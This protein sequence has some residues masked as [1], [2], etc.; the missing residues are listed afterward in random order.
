MQGVPAP[1]VARYFSDDLLELGIFRLALEDRKRAGERK[2]S[3][4][5]GGEVAREKYLVVL[6]DAREHRVYPVDAGEAV[7]TVLRDRDDLPALAPHDRI[8]LK[9][10]ARFR[11][12]GIN[13]SVA[14]F[15]RVAELR[16]PIK[17]TP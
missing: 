12:A 1:H 7:R 17:Y 2:A 14:F 5:H 6:F 13:F 16:H 8:E 4:K 3:G 10:V 9:T 11:D 15:R